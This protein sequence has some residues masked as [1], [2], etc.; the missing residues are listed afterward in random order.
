MRFMCHAPAQLLLGKPDVLDGLLFVVDSFGYVVV[1][2]VIMLESMGLPLP[3][4]TVLLTAAA[5][6]ATGRLHL[7][8][9]VAAAA[10]GAIVGDSVGYWVGRRGG[11][12]LLE[13]CG[14]LIRVNRRHLARAERFFERHGAKTVFVGRF[15]AFLRMFAGPLAGVARMSYPRFF[16]FNVLGGVAW[17]ASMGLLGHAFGRNLPLLERLVR[18]IGIWSAVAVLAAVALALFA[19]QRLSRQRPR[20]KAL[21]RPR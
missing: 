2:A 1:A 5:Y 17:A 18:W 20:E 14:R 13:R 4:E 9:V 15:V 12:A 8:G 16:A 21:D 6:S 7:S 11:L 10:I 3:G 19:R